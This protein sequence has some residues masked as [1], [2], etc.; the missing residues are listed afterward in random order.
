M[1]Q[2]ETIIKY[3]RENPKEKTHYAEIAKACNISLSGVRGIINMSIK[4]GT[5]FV[6]HG[7]GFYSLKA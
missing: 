2:K 6:R 5:D 7:G 4:K 3:L 1:T